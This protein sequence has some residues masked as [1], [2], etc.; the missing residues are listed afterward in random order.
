MDFL[1]E[2]VLGSIDLELGEKL[3]KT[4]LKESYYI[5]RYRDDYRIFVDDVTDGDLIIKILSEVL[6]GYGLRLNT[7][8][9]SFNHDIV[10]GSLKA[11]KIYALTFGPVPAKLNKQELLRQLLIL[12]RIGNKFPNAGT[13]K[14]RLSKIMEA[15]APSNFKKQ[16]DVVTGILIDIGYNNPNCFSLVAGMLSLYVPTMRKLRQKEILG[17][18]NKKIGTLANNGLLETWMQRIS[19]GLK[20]DLDFNEP[21]CKRVSGKNGSTIFNSDWITDQGLKDVISNGPCIDK[22]ILDEIK[23]KIEAVEINI[24]EYE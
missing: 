15:V 21:L 16:E 18:V 4:K 22:K 8:K 17:I 7:L 11:D 20:L 14:S 13:L 9:T 2:I 3:K 5:L 6:V 23:P 10:G 24:F 1:A 19:V 12:Q